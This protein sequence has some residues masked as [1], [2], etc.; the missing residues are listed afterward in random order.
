[1]EMSDVLWG[2]ISVGVGVFIAVYG[3]MLFTFTLAAMGFD[4]I[5]TR[6]RKAVVQLVGKPE[7]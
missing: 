4:P 1:M 7:I 2:L 3:T 6:G 5:I